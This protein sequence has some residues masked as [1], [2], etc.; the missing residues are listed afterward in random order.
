MGG[1]T[2]DYLCVQ[3]RAV[4]SGDEK[5]ELEAERASKPEAPQS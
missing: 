2:G 4:F 5:R 3:C 1:W